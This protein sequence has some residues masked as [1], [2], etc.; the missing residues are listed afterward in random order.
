MRIGTGR[1][2]RTLGAVV[3]ALTT[4][5]ALRAGSDR[6][7]SAGGQAAAAGQRVYLAKKCDRCH[8]IGG[9]GNMRFPLDGVGARLSE[10]D[11]RRWLTD[12]A[13][14]EA[15]LPRQP[16]VRMSEWIASNRRISAPDIDALVAYLAALK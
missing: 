13:E 7:L 10:A 16:A 15:A 3:I 14:M 2:V 11:L 5:A 9:Q 12:T 1:R 6:P 4:V 8:M